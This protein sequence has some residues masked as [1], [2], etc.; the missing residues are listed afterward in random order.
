MYSIEEEW[1]RYNST[2]GGT[3]GYGGAQAGTGVGGVDGV[4][5]IIVHNDGNVSTGNTTTRQT[6]PDGSVVVT[7][8]TDGLREQQ[9]TTPDGIKATTTEHASFIDQNGVQQPSFTEQTI[10]RPDGT[11]TYRLTRDDGYAIEMQVSKD[12]VIESSEYLP[13]GTQIYKTSYPDGRTVENIFAPDDVYIER[14]IA[15]DGHKD[16]FVRYKDGTISHTSINQN[17]GEYTRDTQFA[18]GTT[19]HEVGSQIP[20]S[21][22][23]WLRGR[24]VFTDYGTHAIEVTQYIEKSFLL[25]DSYNYNVK[26]VTR[27]I[28][29]EGITHTET[30]DFIWTEESITPQN[31][32]D[33]FMTFDEFL[34]RLEVVKE[35]FDDVS[36]SGND[37]KKTGTLTFKIGSESQHLESHIGSSQ[38]DN[39]QGLGLLYGAAGQDT[40]MGSDNCDILMGGLDNDVLKGGQGADL[41]DGG[42][43]YDTAS[44]ASAATGIVASLTDASQNTG[45]AAGDVYD[46]I[47]GLIGSNFNDKLTGDAAGNTILSNA[48]NDTL[49]GLDGNDRL[50]GGADQDL[51]QGGTGADRL[52]GG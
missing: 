42:S 15:P 13:D 14:Y 47:E 44:Y 34:E 20:I 31:I 23:E 36:T 24:S 26:T 3:V 37:I 45:E 19:V 17:A 7:T 38:G 41:L 49:A 50:F 35:V 11:S 48:G 12:K 1:N 46:G 9:I 27:T 16:I 21:E 4:G 30:T 6:M 22:H 10:D 2:Y 8:V 18:N 39:L 32:N 43:G 40:L 29:E 5:P 28:G 52:D 33:Y 51:L 25:G